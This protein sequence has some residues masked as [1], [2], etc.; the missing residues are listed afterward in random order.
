MVFQSK[1]AVDLKKVQTS[2]GRICQKVEQKEYSRTKIE[3]FFIRKDFFLE[4]G[5]VDDV[6]SKMRISDFDNTQPIFFKKNFSLG[7][8]IIIR[9]NINKKL[10][11]Y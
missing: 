11:S 4:S 9:S 8:K 3:D 7:N 10:L 6:L 5:I 2:L 1:H